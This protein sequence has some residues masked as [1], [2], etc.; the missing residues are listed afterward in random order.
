MP[1]LSKSPASWSAWK[2][3]TLHS[4]AGP[5]LGALIFMAGL[6]VY[7][8]V[9]HAYTTTAVV[10]ILMMFG[11][12]E[13]GLLLFA[14]FIAAGVAAFAGGWIQ[15][16]ARIFLVRPW[17]LV[18][19]VGCC[20]AG[21]QFVYL[22]ILIGRADFSEAWVLVLLT[23]ITTGGIAR[24]VLWREGPRTGEPVEAELPSAFRHWTP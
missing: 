4:L 23:A 19:T 21:A 17:R 1:L 6:F 15:L 20:A 16:V 18:A 10:A 8:L 7:G 9:F 14:S 22:R 12:R 13:V 11:V 24:F 2:V 3:V 5:P